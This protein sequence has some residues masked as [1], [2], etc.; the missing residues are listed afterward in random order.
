MAGKYSS[1]TRRQVRVIPK[2]NINNLNYDLYTTG[3]LDNI[4]SNAMPAP[5]PAAISN[6]TG[7]VEANP[8]NPNNL[9][10]DLYITGSLENILANGM[11]APTQPIS[12]INPSPYIDKVINLNNVKQAYAIQKLLD[13][14]PQETQ[15]ELPDGIYLITEDGYYL[16]T[17]NNEYIIL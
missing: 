12:K 1:N 8:I 2:I 15:S 4:V 14:I 13:T 5:K 16:T 6:R 10:N 3:S 9:N 17:E 7:V 11:P